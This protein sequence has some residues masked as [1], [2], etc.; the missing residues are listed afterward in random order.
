MKFFPAKTYIKQAIALALLA[1]IVACTLNQQSIFPVKVSE[2]FAA[3]ISADSTRNP[4]NLVALFLVKK[5]NLNNKF[6]GEIYPIA[7]LLNNHYIEV[8][9]D[10]TQDTRL[11]ASPDRIIELNNQRIFLNTIKDFIVISGHQRLGEFQVEKPIVSQFACSSIITGQGNFPGQTSLPAIFERIGQ[12]QSD[13]FQGYR[14]NQKFDETWRTAIAVS[15]AATLSQPPAASEAELTRYRQDIITLGKNAIAQVARGKKVPSEAVVEGV[16][17]VDL[18][19]DGLPEVFGKVRQGATTQATASQQPTPMGFAS[20][21]MTYKDG[22]P[23]LL[24]TIQ[25]SVLLE[26]RRSPYDLLE[27]I[28]LNN[29]GIDEVI[30]KQ[31]GYED[32]RF[33][34]YEYK[35]NK[36]VRV[37]SGAAYGC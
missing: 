11:Y 32:T 8:S 30:A 21:W 28:D 5:D 26:S 15:Q 6:R 20:I 23:Q 29:D 18:N 36:L 2:S 16:Q 31:T 25:A 13:G 33:E 17:V 3:I 19:R 22:K 27:T 7:L 10:V 4:K 9:N 1:S 34:I 24:E 14:G 12:E 37:F 35:N